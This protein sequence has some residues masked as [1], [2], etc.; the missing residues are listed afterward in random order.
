MADLGNLKAFAEG[1]LPEVQK[2]FKLASSGAN[3]SNSAPTT[4]AIARLKALVA[5]ASTTTPA[6]LE[7]RVGA[8]QAERHALTEILL[9][10]ASTN[11][12]LAETDVRVIQLQ[13]NALRD[14]MAQIVEVAVFQDIAQLL[15]PAEIDELVKSLAQADSDIRARQRA[16]DILDIVVQVAILA[17]NIA[18]KL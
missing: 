1:I 16:K 11:V 8:I 9:S 10:A 2:L 7:A 13:R 5:A 18:T 12:S 17:G 4:D 15:T 6:T 3:A 14:R